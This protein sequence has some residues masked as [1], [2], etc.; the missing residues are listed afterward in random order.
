MI[1]C[2]KLAKFS[3]WNIKCG[4]LPKKGS[5]ILLHTIDFTRHM[6]SDMELTNGLQT[7]TCC[8]IITVS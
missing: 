6:P 2:Q 7:T 5:F 8:C 1:M 4:N 3:N